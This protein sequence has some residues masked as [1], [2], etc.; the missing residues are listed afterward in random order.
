MKEWKVN[1]T[2]KRYVGK[3]PVECYG[4]IYVYAE[5]MEEAILTAKK[6]LSPDAEISRCGVRK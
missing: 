5:T 2:T 6:E 3:H 4:K 1:Y